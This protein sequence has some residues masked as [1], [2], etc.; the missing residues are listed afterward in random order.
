[1]KRKLTLK[2]I[3]K[4]MNVYMAMYHVG[5]SEN[6][7]RNY[8][9]LEKLKD[10]AFIVLKDL[11]RKKV[12]FSNTLSYI[13]CVVEY[14][15]ILSFMFPIPG[16]TILYDKFSLGV[17]L[18][19]FAYFCAIFQVT[20]YIQYS[21]KLVFILGIIAIVIVF[22]YMLL[23]YFSY[24]DL[25]ND[26]LFQVPVYFLNLISRTLLG[27][28]LV[29]ILNLLFLQI[30]SCEADSIVGC[31]SSS[32]VIVVVISY[33]SAFLYIFCVF[34]YNLIV[35]S[36]D[37]ASSFIQSSPNARLECLFVFF[38]VSLCLFFSSLSKLTFGVYFLA[39]LILLQNLVLFYSFVTLLPYFCWHFNILRSIC[40][41]LLLWTS[42]TIVVNVF[43][44]NDI[45][46]I[47]YL[48]I[49]FV[50]GFGYSL[51]KLRRNEILDLKNSDLRSP[52][53]VE[54]K[55][56]FILEPVT[57]Y[58]IVKRSDHGI[59]GSEIDGVSIGYSYEALLSVHQTAEEMDREHGI[60]SS[61]IDEADRIY[62]FGLRHFPVSAM[63]I[64]RAQVYSI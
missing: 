57:R 39:I 46:V 60:H 19:W 32:H 4:C 20:P 2:M 49:P 52:A 25:V 26:R 9:F 58:L 53:E 15:Q 10:A 14:L 48:L 50:C 7:G 21:G 47:F 30:S 44:E 43:T 40:N 38:K 64:L 35:F 62:C 24:K 16:N 59:L 55:A 23:V 63:Y 1:M 51:C 42:F 33:L 29:P 34:L 31:W 41:A 12:G 28:L 3:F 27:I 54:L 5:R 11:N 18:D 6:S 37:P 36:R 17:I 13:Y 22:M 45:D 61:L 8:L 56:R